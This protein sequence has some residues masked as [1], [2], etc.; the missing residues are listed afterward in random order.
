MSSWVEDS[1]KMRYILRRLWSATKDVFGYMAL[2]FK[3]I[4]RTKTNTTDLRDELVLRARLKEELRL[5]EREGKAQ[6]RQKPEK[7]EYWIL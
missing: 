3:K 2:P 7:K 4:R 1:S 6:A 5:A